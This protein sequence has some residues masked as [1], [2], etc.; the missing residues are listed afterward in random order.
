MYFHR[1]PAG[2]NRAGATASSGSKI[3]RKEHLIHSR[4]EFGMYTHRKLRKSIIF[5]TIVTKRKIYE[6]KIDY[7]VS[8]SHAACCV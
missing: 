3:L 2:N 5:A 7:V 1:R 4:K 8:G 6:K